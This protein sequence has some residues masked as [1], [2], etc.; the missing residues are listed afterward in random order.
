MQRLE[1]SGAVRPIYGSLGVKRLTQQ[2]WWGVPPR[3]YCSGV[4]Y[5]I[6]KVGRSGTLRNPRKCSPRNFGSNRQNKYTALCHRFYQQF[7]T[8][9]PSRHVNIT[10]SPFFILEIIVGYHS[11]LTCTHPT[12]PHPNPTDFALPSSLRHAWTTAR[13]AL[14]QDCMVLFRCKMAVYLYNRGN[15][16]LHCVDIMLGTTKLKEWYISLNI[17]S[18]AR[19][20]CLLSWGPRRT[21][22]FFCNFSTVWCG[23]LLKLCFFGFLKL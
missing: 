17:P 19:Q 13:R 9:A 2:E 15:E 1:V 12:L 23:I 20:R 18:V 7:C 11:L 5:V 14:P 3:A 22:W 16:H 21:P 10:N 8:I 6:S 4:Q